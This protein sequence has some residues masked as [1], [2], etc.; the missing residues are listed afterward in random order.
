MTACRAPAMMTWWRWHTLTSSH[1]DPALN[2][3][4]E[5]TRYLRQ[6]FNCQLRWG[7]CTLPRWA[8]GSTGGFFSCRHNSNQVCSRLEP[9]V[10]SA[11][12]CGESSSL[13]W[14]LSKCWSMSAS[15][16]NPLKFVALILPITVKTQFSHP[17]PL[18]PLVIPSE[19]WN[20]TCFTPLAQGEISLCGCFTKHVWKKPNHTCLVISTRMCNKTHLCGQS[21]TAGPCVVCGFYHTRVGKTKHVWKSHIYWR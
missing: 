6:V 2:T 15:C 12:Q 19:G 7:H 3:K 21:H 5:G 10:R 18:A 9:Q 1:R 13:T 17:P 11:E 8:K 20:F 14:S 16:L 4:G